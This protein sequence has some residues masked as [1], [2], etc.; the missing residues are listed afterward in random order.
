MWIKP[1]ENDGNRSFLYLSRQFL[2]RSTL[3]VRFMVSE[4]EQILLIR[5][6][7]KCCVSGSPKNFI[8]RPARQ[9]KE[10]FINGRTEL[11][12]SLCVQMLPS[13]H[14]KLPVQE[15]LKLIR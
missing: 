1:A 10:K 5:T 2:D 13:V 6:T 14:I 8:F 12:N 4:W 11:F 15:T 9:T 3:N 7:F